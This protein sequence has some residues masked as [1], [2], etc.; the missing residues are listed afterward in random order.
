MKRY[1]LTAIGPFRP[2]I[3]QSITKAL[4]A[5]K[6]SIGD[7]TIATLEDDHF[8][9]VLMLSLPEKKKIGS[10]VDGLRKVEKGECITLGLKEAPRRSKKTHPGNHIITIYGAD[11]SGIV[12][13]TASALAKAGLTITNLETKRIIAGKR[14]LCIITIEVFSPEDVV[15]RKAEK[16]LKMLAARLKMRISVRALP[17][18]SL[19]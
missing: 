9:A 14:T 5:H 13:R 15:I 12:Y 2:G 3:I 19:S 7:S 18:F 17:A 6:C 8:G 16:R 4:Y 11:K 10:L 1:A